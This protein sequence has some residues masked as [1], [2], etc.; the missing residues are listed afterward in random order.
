MGE[1]VI[2][3][4]VVARD[5]V[6]REGEGLSLDEG[7]QVLCLTRIAEEGGHLTELT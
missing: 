2:G 4:L 7:H 3:G 1:A 5:E 6:E